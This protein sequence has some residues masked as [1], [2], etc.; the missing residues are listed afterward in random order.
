[1]FLLD[2]TIAENLF[3]FVFLLQIDF[4]EF[5]NDSVIRGARAGKY[6]FYL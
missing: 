2:N 5:E 1:M 4:R 6:A 3:L